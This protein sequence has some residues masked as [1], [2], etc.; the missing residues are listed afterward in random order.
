[1][2]WHEY[3]NCDH[4][5]ATILCQTV[6]RHLETALIATLREEQSSPVSNEDGEEEDGENSP[7]MLKQ[8]LTIYPLCLTGLCYFS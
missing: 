1:M 6:G 2:T 4:D 8:L 7:I 5:L 3:G